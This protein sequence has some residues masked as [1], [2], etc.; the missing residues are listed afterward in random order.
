M[1]YLITEN[2]GF[3]PQYN[4]SGDIYSQVVTFE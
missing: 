2:A 3:A 1:D 4:L